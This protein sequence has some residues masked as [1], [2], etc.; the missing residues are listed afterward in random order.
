MTRSR[1]YRN[2][3]QN[4]QRQRTPCRCLFVRSLHPNMITCFAVKTRFRCADSRNYACRWPV[5]CYI[6]NVLQH[7]KSKLNRFNKPALAVLLIGLVLLLNAMT[8]VPALHELIHKDADSANHSCAVTLFAHGH[9]ESAVCDVPA[10]L[11][12]TFVETIP[13]L[14]FSIFSMVIENLPPGRAPPS[15]VSPLV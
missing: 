13:H 6:A 12:A 14:E 3:T 8:A 5:I 15:V 1:G 2:N 7:V 9:V 11:S 4:S 10:V